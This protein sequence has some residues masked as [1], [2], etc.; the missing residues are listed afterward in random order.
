MSNR[1]GLAIRSRG[2]RKTWAVGPISWRLEN[3]SGM[4]DIRAK[5]CGIF[6]GGGKREWKGSVWKE[7]DAKPEDRKDQ[8]VR[9]PDSSVPG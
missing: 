2:K 6:R 4:T 8:Q 5:D 1:R 9:S 7:R 3:A